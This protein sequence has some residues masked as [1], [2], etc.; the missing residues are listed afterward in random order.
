VAVHPALT[1]ATA[2]RPSIVAVRSVLADATAARPS[3]NTI[4]LRT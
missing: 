4:W 2:A 1:D 3:I